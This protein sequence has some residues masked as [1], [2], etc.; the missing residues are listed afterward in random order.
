MFFLKF[1]RLRFSIRKAIGPLLEHSGILNIESIRP[2]G[3]LEF[4]IKG[5]SYKPNYPFSVVVDRLNVRS[6]FF[7]FYFSRSKKID[8]SFSPLILSLGSKEKPVEGYTNKQGSSKPF[9]LQFIRDGE[10]YSI[11]S[12]TIDIEGI[13]WIEGNVSF[14]KNALNAAL[15]IAFSRDLIRKAPEPFFFKNTVLD[16]EGFDVLNL[17]ASSQGEVFDIWMKSKLIDFKLKR[18]LVLL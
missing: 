2:S 3:L 5:I 18:K 7:S 6:D 13:A 10:T 16:K 12:V 11:P 15:R 9:E 17:R 4:R 14:E 8:L 1:F